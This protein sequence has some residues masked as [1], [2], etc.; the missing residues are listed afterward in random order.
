MTGLYL[1][2]VATGGLLL[3]KRRAGLLEPRLGDFL[4]G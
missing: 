4:L 3:G 2:E 1:A